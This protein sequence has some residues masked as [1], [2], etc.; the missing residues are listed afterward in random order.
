[1]G[2]NTHSLQHLQKELPTL[3]STDGTPG[4]EK[5]GARTDK[6]MNEF[7]FGR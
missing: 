5:V 7:H 6:E 3:K 1:M 2:H 4:V